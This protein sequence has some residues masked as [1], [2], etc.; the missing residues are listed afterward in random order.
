MAER[1]DIIEILEKAMAD[2]KAGRFSAIGICGIN[3][4]RE[5]LVSWVF[6]EQNT[7]ERSLLTGCAQLLVEKIMTDADPIEPAEVRIGDRI[8]FAPNPRWPDLQVEARVV[9]FRKDIHVIDTPRR[10]SHQGWIDTV[11]D[12]GTERSVRPSR[13]QRVPA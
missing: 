5:H 13:C 12:A 2:A 3:G 10:R 4:N 8:R 7:A 9:R 1:I 11:D 6:D